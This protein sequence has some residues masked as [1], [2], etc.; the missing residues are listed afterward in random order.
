LPPPRQLPD[1]EA[2]GAACALVRAHGRDTLSFFKLRRDLH[3]LFSADRRAFLGYRVEGRVLLVAGDPVGPPESLPGLVSEAVRFAEM[4]GL[5]IAAIGTSAP[6]LP[7]WRD[8][9]LLPLYIGDEAILETE[10]FSLEGRAI[11]K[12]RQ[13]VSRLEKAGYTVDA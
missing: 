5:E 11:R 2:H 9:G 12:V 10:S 3:Y 13:S 7:L 4:R 8:G 1:S 6:L